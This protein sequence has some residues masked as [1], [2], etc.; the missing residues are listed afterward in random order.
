MQKDVPSK[1][2]KGNVGTTKP[3]D[4]GN[5][6]LLTAVLKGKKIIENDN[7]HNSTTSKLNK[8]K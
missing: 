6:H 5:R 2:R 8:Y 7:K 1:Q 4:Q 3:V